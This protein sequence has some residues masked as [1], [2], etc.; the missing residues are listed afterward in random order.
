MTMSATVEL[1]PHAD[2][3]PVEQA[4]VDSIADGYPPEMYLGIAF[5]RPDGGCRLWHGWTD[6]GPALGDQVDGLAVAAGLDACDWLHIGDRH[7]SLT[8]RG[9]IRIEA[10]PLRPILADVQG[11]ERGPEDRRE[12]LLRVIAAAAER[13]GQTPRPGLPAWPGFG[14]AR[15]LRKGTGR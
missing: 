10:Y 14:P 12:G 4:V 11:G 1:Q 13:T 15:L 5:Y 9:R 2:P 8:H 7:S 3:T 6:G